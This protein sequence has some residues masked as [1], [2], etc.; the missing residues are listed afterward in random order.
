MPKGYKTIN[1]NE[2]VYSTLSKLADDTAKKE[3]LSRVSLAQLIERMIK[4]Y[5]ATKWWSASLSATKS[6]P[7]LATPAC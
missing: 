5:K 7:G 3:G 4:I 2:T 1:V 6:I